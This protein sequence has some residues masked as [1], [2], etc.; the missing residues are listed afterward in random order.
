M[1]PF[2][3]LI[4]LIGAAIGLVYLEFA[5][6]AIGLLGLGAAAVIWFVQQQTSQAK[7]QSNSADIISTGGE[8]K[9]QLLLN[10]FSNAKLI[11]LI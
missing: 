11:C 9:R 3:L 1:N 7:D 10:S 4:G 6:L 8:G 2:L 5:Y